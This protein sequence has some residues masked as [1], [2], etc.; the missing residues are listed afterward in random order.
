MTSESQSLMLVG[1][2]PR[3]AMMTM[4]S[5][6]ATWACVS[7]SGNDSSWLVWKNRNRSK[8]HSPV[9]ARIVDSSS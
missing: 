6:A 4:L 9:L 1:S 5:L 7:S 3:N 2:V 8:P